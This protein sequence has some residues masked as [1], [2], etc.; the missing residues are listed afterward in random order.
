MK[1]TDEQIKE[2]AEELDIGMR[3]FYNLKTKEVKIVLN[4]DPDEYIGIEEDL[5]EDELQ[6]I[7]EN[8]DDYFEFA[9][10]ES[11]DSFRVMQDFAE[12]VDDER[13]QERLIDSLE[14]VKPFKNF[15]LRIDNSGEYRQKWFD[16]KD[17]QYIEWVKN[18]ISA[19]NEFKEE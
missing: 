7:E 14:G 2:I 8:P 12:S 16:F 1:L 18:Q 6:D 11:R 15:K 13:L 10:M 4:I 5:P 17:L 3:C 19:Y 9:N